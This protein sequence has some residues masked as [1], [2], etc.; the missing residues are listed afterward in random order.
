MPDID[1]TARM[2]WAWA[3]LIVLAV[4]LP[5]AVWLRSRNLTPPRELYDGPIPKLNRADRWLYDRY[6]LGNLDR[7]RIRQAVIEGRELSEPPLREAARGLA[8]AWLAG[9][10]GWLT[11]KKERIC[12]GADLCLMTVVLVVAIVT[13]RDSLLAPVVIGVLPLP[14]AARAWKRDRQRVE[15]AHRL[16]A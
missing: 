16:N 11:R 4:A 6:Q 14:L 13:G 9:E 2:P 5:A 3:L 8:A 1:R 10:A 12:L 15:R 7:S